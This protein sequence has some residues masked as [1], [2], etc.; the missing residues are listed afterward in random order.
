M[1]SK[2]AEMHIAMSKAVKAVEEAQAAVQIY[3][4]LGNTSGAS[5]ATAVLNIAYA[6]SGKVDKAPGRGAALSILEDLSRAVDNQNESAWNLAMDDLNK[7][8]AYTTKDL[9]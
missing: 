7:N 5:D 6:E 9:K 3:N 8:G 4:E 2:T 1:L